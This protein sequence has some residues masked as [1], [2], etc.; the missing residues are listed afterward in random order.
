MGRTAPAV[1]PRT[2]PDR[3]RHEALLYAGQP[4]FLAGTVPFIAAALEAGEP[5]LVVVDPQKIGLL[6][7]ELGLAAS[8]VQFADMTEL[9]ANPA[10][11]I[12]AWSQFL[13]EHQ[14]DGHRV[15][16]IS[17]PI[18]AGREGPDLVEC[19]VHESLL[20]LAFEDTP[21]WRLLCPYDVSALDEPII[22]EARRSHPI[23]QQGHQEQASQSYLGTGVTGAPLGGPLPPVPAGARS[24]PIQ[25]NALR[26]VRTLVS[27]AG[28]DAGLSDA[29][30]A[31]LVVAVNEIA[32]NSIRHST[33]T[34]TLRVWQEHLALICEV[35]DDGHI[36]NPL[37]GRQLAGS[38]NEGGRGLW[39]ANQLCDLVQV[40]SLPSGNVVRAHMRR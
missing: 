30:T 33:G 26:L 2:S 21:P 18:W 3:F 36:S 32:T 17:E 37:V 23:I 27:R 22:D 15:R 1:A 19:Q 24:L 5:V 4:E 6:R 8:A 28:H 7:V 29:R 31:D 40:R 11:I 13:A 12:P 9:G 39:L 34:G 16:G 35:T 25:L 38:D 14:G 10:R 20:N